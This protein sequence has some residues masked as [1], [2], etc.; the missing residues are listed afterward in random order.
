MGE[1]ARSCYSLGD[2]LR[3]RRGNLN[4][5]SIRFHAFA[6]FACILG[7]DVPD[8]LNFGGNDIELFANLL[9]DSGKLGPARADLFRFIYIV[10]D[11]CP[12]QILGKRLAPGFLA[13]MFGNGKWC[14]FLFFFEDFGFI[15][16]ME[17]LATFYFIGAAFFTL[18]R[19]NDLFQDINALLQILYLRFIRSDSILDDRFEF[20]SCLR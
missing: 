11:I 3:R 19:K 4:R 1:Q 2:N 15:K 12:G 6:I 17:L 8:Y 14:F 10:N 20:F 7:P 16:Y 5:R 13:R 9:A 18:G